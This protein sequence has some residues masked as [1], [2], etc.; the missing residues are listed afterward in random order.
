M[1]VW[2]W[3]LLA[4]YNRQLSSANNNVYAWIKNHFVS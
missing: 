3:V 1:G 2:D 4:I